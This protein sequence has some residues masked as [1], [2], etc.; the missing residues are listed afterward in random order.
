MNNQA[1]SKVWIIVI[2]LVLIAGGILAWQLITEEDEEELAIA[3]DWSC[4]DSVTFTYKGEEV[5]YGTVESQGGCWMDRNLGAD[6]VATAYDDADAYGDLFQ[7]GRL[8]DGHQDRG[9]ETT[10]TL[11]ITDNPGHSKFILSLDDL[12][13]DWRSPHNDNLWQGISGINNPCP[14][15]WR[16]PT[17]TE[18]DT[19]RAS[20]SQQNYN[21]AYASSLKLTAAGRRS[22]VDDAL[23]YHEGS[24]GYYWSSS[25]RFPGARVL[26]F[27]SKEASMHGYV[28][29]F[30]CSV[31]CLKKG[32]IQ[33]A[34][35]W[36]EYVLEE[37][38]Q[39]FKS[40]DF[41]DRRL[42][43]IQDNGQRDIIV[44]SIKEALGES[45]E[46]TSWYPKEI[47]FPP[48][49]SKIFFVKYLS[50]TGHSAGLVMFNVKNLTFKELTETGKIYQNYSN[51]T[52][53]IS[54]DGLK[55][56]SLGA[57]ELYLLDL[58]TDRAELLVKA[59]QGEVF[60]PAKEVPD[61][62]WIDDYTIQ[63]P[64][65]S[66]EKI[67]DLP[68][69]VRL[70]SIDW[71]TYRNEE[72]GFEIKYPPNIVDNAGEHVET[73]WIGEN[74]CLYGGF[75]YRIDHY[76]NRFA[77]LICPLENETL[78]Q[79][80]LREETDCIDGLEKILKDAD[81]ITIDGKQ[82]IK[83][84]NPPGSCPYGD[85]ITIKTYFQA[86]SKIYTFGFYDSEATPEK[87]RI[88]NQI[89]S[90]LKFIE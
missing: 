38:S 11:S 29:A 18:L 81:N 10:D 75:I 69:E 20:W 56:A 80:I 6:R 84:V 1:F 30:G 37:I 78:E 13:Y 19:E 24:D 33:T 79:W 14:E 3:E 28:R 4:G 57:K 62:V 67:Y 89:L 74:E 44:P 55:I 16:L 82:G 15:G 68:I 87:E 31:R 60:Y 65:F 51:Y 53:L 8:D 76:F 52:S 46:D 12:P 72:Y 17:E 35:E 86:D 2:L 40:L 27:S 7:W 85:K 59:D 36:K 32:G 66:V 49:S 58:L 21:G 61:F 22:Y 26:D 70:I 34:T 39:D 43:G 50:E 64:V 41:Y 73:M 63:Y 25:A 71:K 88:F 45:R 48:Y 90:T 9:S 54:P 47:S 5:T 77:M 42:I 83:I 23:C